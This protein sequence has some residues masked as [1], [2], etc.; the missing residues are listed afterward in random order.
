MFKLFTLYVHFF[1]E[2]RNIT[3]IKSFP[4]VSLSWPVDDGFQN[5]SF[6]QYHFVEIKDV[7]FLSHF[8]RGE[9]YWS[10]ESNLFD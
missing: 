4:P 6:T 3:G 5:Y 9:N 1:M 7:I 10:N 8:H 2:N